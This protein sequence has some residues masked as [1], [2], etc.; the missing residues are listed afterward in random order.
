MYSIENN[1]VFLPTPDPGTTST[2]AFK[3][4]IPIDVLFPSEL[5]IGFVQ[6]SYKSVLL[7][8]PPHWGIPKNIT[9]RPL[10]VLPSKKEKEKRE[11]R[12][13]TT[14]FALTELGFWMCRLGFLNQSYGDGSITKRATVDLQPI[15]TT[16]VVL[17][18]KYWPVYPYNIQSLL[19]ISVA[20]EL[21]DSFQL[22]TASGLLLLVFLWIQMLPGE[23]GGKRKET[24][25]LTTV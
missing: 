25:W 19:G 18:L 10:L 2:F 1:P 4:H 24:Y 23:A 12:G 6:V 5:W 21:I 13:R 15:R 8:T 7:Y 20:F 16:R 3:K 17:S 22:F 14:S 11:T 9:Y